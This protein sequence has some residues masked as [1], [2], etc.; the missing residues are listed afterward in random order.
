MDQGSAVLPVGA[1][2][3]LYTDGLVE[4]RDRPI[5]E[6]IDQLATL[7]ADHEG[8]TSAL[9]A[10]LVSALVPGDG[11]DDVAVLVACVCDA[12][13]E[14]T[15]ALAIR[16]EPGAVPEARAFVGE[17]L[18]AWG[19]PDGLVRDAVLLVSELVSNAILHGRPPIAL[20]L[21]RT[22]EELLVEVDDC[23]TV[24]PRKLRP[25]P[26]DEHGRGLVIASLLADRWGTRPLRDGKSVW[27]LFALHRYES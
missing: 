2:L 5:D 19:T 6:G 25:T 4:R 12:E 1:R 11:D 14:L 9:P 26:E 23:A 16:P 21:R 27:S 7:L 22:A 15:A 17:Q 20:R 13:D 18:R 10:A 8:D 24:L 3:A